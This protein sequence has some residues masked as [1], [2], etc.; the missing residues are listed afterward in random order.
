M[1]RSSKL[2]V[3]RAILQTIPSYHV[4]FSIDIIFSSVVSFG[5]YLLAFVVAVAAVFGNQEY[6]F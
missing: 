6:I 3:L 2:K 1:T 5:F 4:R